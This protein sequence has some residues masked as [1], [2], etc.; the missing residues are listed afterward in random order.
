MSA[1]APVEGLLALGREPGDEVS[2]QR[3]AGPCAAGG[4]GDAEQ[5]VRPVAPLHALQ[6]EAVAGLS[7]EVELGLQAGRASEEAEETFV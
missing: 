5:V 7:R 4:F 2:P 6:D 3:N 1:Q